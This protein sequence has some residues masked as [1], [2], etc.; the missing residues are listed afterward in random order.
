MSKRQPPFRPGEPV[1]LELD[2]A[3][4][5]T[6][7]EFLEYQRDPFGT[8]RPAARV[9]DQRDGRQHVIDPLSIQR[10]GP[11]YRVWRDAHLA[12]VGALDIFE[13]NGWRMVE[14]PPSVRTGRAPARD[15]SNWISMN[16]LML[17]PRTAVVEE[18]E[19]PMMELLR[20]LGCEVV[21]CPFDRVY[22]FGGGLHCCT[23]DVRREGGLQSYF[24]AERAQ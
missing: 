9:L 1:M 20:S 18:A 14:A 19:Q 4:W 7:A 12:W 24:T 21:P 16:I 13:A 17:D 22:P 5:F 15:V 23:A 10:D 3:P 2:E 8:S 11:I 6:E